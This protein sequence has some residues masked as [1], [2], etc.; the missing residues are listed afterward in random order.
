VKF[1]ELVEELNTKIGKSHSTSD[2]ACMFGIST[3]T[4]RNWNSQEKDLS[5]QQVAA[6]VL[7]SRDSAVTGA[8]IDLV[9]PIVEYFPIE[10]SESDRGTR[11]LVLDKNKEN[12]LYTQGL[13]EHL[14]KNSGI[15]I[16]YDS[17]GCAIYVGKAREQSLWTEINLA[18]NRKRD[19]DN[20]TLVRHPEG[21]T[22]FQPGTEKLRQPKEM[23][24]KI[25]DIS[26]Y[27]SAYA[28]DYESIDPLEA[29]L[30]RGFANSLLNER[31]EKFI[32][33]N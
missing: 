24:L 7:G 21:N 16:F 26:R 32:R 20:I 19:V 25:G 12:S 1:S 6:L 17:R 33:W 14:K 13:V 10:P 27:F 28:A 15:Y 29:L 18:F 11:Q 31:M 3:S 9:R 8:Q 30:I 23:D 5:P 2:L 4:V 22:K